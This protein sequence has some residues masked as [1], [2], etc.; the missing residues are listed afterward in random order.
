[1]TKGECFLG[2]A[3]KQ[4]PDERPKGSREHA[5]MKIVLEI[6]FL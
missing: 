5:D 4:F 2:V 6:Q 1:M 3:K